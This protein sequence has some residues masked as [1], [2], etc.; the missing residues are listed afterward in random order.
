M[1]DRLIAASPYV[2]LYLALCLGGVG[3][4]IPEEVPVAHG[5]RARPSG[6]RPLVARPAASASP[7]VVTGDLVLYVTGRR[8][9]ERVLDLRLVRA[10]P[11]RRATRRAGGVLS[12]LRHAH[13]LR[14]A[15]RDGTA[16]RRLRDG[17]GGEAPL[18][19]VRRRRRRGHR[20]RHPAELRHRLLLHG[21]PARHPR[22]TCAASRAGS[23][24]SSWSGRPPGS[25]SSSGVGAT[26]CSRSACSATAPGP[27]SEELGAGHTE[28]R[29][30]RRTHGDA[31]RGEAL[32][33]DRGTSRWGAIGGSGAL[34]PISINAT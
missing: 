23:R 16:G 6:R 17:R 20:L 14:G 29:S 15:P 21:A 30:A 11:R 3:F 31:R 32:R 13:R 5:G 28:G 4:P 8:W 25:A 12:A 22:P 19:E 10:L 1:L 7:G 27:R 34:P 9:G 18:L 2:G 26:A 24:S 33:E